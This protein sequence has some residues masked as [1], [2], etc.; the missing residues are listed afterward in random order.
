MLTKLTYYPY[1]CKPED[2]LKAQQDMRATYCYS[3]TQVFGEYP[4]YL[5]SRF[6][7]NGIAIKKELGD[8]ELMKNYPVDFV[9]FSYYMSSCTAASTEG[10]DFTPVIQYLQLKIRIYPQVSGD[11]K[12]IQLDLE[13]QW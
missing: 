3:D 13:S 8:D 10:L 11:G 6:K 7:N 4:A 12:L 5:I 1:T 9:S 2:V